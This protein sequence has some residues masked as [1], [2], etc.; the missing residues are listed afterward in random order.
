MGGGGGTG[1]A[2]FSHD[3]RDRGE[4]MGGGGRDGGTLAMQPMLYSAMMEGKGWGG[5]LAMQP[6]L[7]SAMMEGKGWGGDTGHAAH[8]VSELSQQ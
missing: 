4:G 3:G 6:M 2:V 7:Y 5:T 1:H 8:A